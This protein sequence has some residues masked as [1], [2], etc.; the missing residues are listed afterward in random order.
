MEEKSK[1]GIRIKNAKR[2]MCKFKMDNS[3]TCTLLQVKLRLK[4]VT[5]SDA[6]TISAKTGSYLQL[7]LGWTG[8]PKVL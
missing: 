2:E 7:A 5:R 8:M 6:T 4:W 3:E 1:R